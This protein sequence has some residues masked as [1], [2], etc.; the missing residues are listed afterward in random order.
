MRLD[1][2]YSNVTLRDGTV[3]ELRAPRVSLSDFTDGPLDPAVTPSLLLA[4]SL[5]IA[6]RIAKVDTAALG[7][8][9]VFGHKASLASLKDAVALAFS[10]D[11]G[12]STGLLPS[13]A[14][15]CSVHQ[16]ACRAGPHGATD[17]DVEIAPGILSA[18][19]VYIESLPA[20]EAPQRNESVPDG[21][22]IFVEAKCAQCHTPQAPGA[23]GK[24]VELFSDLRRHDLGAGLAGAAGE[25][26]ASAQEWRTAPLLGVSERLA[27]G[28]TL[29]HDGRARSVE[30]AI[31]WHDGEAR[32]AR[33][34]FASLSAADRTKLKTY[35]SGR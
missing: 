30:E 33:D 15:D 21:A 22:K 4:P 6:A 12:L 14:G 5:K 8:T 1:W 28:S 24:P 26:A 25:G 10:R 11:L 29:L 2:I 35:I 18:I 23:F 34:A 3:V 9:N 32:S 16:A 13:A 7:L 31:L 17:G 27:V 20:P 19:S